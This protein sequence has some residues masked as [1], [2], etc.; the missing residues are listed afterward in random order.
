MNDNAVNIPND[1]PLSAAE[2]VALSSEKYYPDTQIISSA[3]MDAISSARESFADLSSVS[4]H[5]APSASDNILP[6][7]QSKVE[8]AQ[9]G[10]AGWLSRVRKKVAEAWSPSNPFRTS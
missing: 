5:N 1:T 9:N 4:G 8:P 2:P 10:F 6:F 3:Q 7:P